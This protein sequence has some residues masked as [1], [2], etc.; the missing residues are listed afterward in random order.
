MS[1]ITNINDIESI[2]YSGYILSST[3]YHLESMLKPGVNAPDINRFCTE[4]IRSYDA[5]PSFLGYS[6]FPHAVCF[7]LNNEVV[8]GLCLPEKILKAGDVLSLDL[9]VDYKGLFTDMAITY[10]ITEEG[11]D[12]T[13]KTHFIENYK[14]IKSPDTAFQQTLEHNRKREL[15]DV[16]QK[17]L[18]RAISILKHGARVG[19]IGHAVGSYLA[20][21]GFGNV[22]ELGGH[23]LG[24]KVHEP[25]FISHSGRKGTGQVLIE[26]MIIAIEPM[27]TAG[28]T[29]KVRFV[30]NKE[31]GWDEILSTDGSLAAHFEHTFMITKHGCDILTKIPHDKVLPI[32]SIVFQDF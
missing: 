23:G 32:K 31:F 25:P 10:I 11:V 8:H 21:R 18:A 9:G 30:K 16:T 29:G 7:S 1:I 24:Y 14:D 5:E 27:V 4:F 13:C 2:R 20:S 26:N 17:S 6:G 22:T 3:Y 15:L 28:P 19:D 12:R